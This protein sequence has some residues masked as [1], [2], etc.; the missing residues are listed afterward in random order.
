MHAAMLTSNDETALS[1]TAVWQLLCDFVYL[2]YIYQNNC[3][4]QC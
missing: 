3:Y 4:R 1:F 2:K